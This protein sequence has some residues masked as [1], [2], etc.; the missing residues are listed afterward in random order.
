MLFKCDKKKQKKPDA[1]KPLFSCVDLAAVKNS[2]PWLRQEMVSPWIIAATRGKSVAW[3]R[4]W[5]S[6]SLKAGQIFVFAPLLRGPTKLF[7]C[8]GL[9]RRWSCSCLVCRARAIGYRQHNREAVGGFFS[10]IGNLYMVHHL[11]GTAQNDRVCCHAEDRAGSFA[12]Q[13]FFRLARE[14]CPMCLWKNMAGTGMQR[15]VGSL[16]NTRDRGRHNGD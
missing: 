13:G 12:V 8:L 10:Q 9:R 16:G 5:M 7:V 14:N 1:F 3:C 6:E 15:P 11:W 2:K 4:W